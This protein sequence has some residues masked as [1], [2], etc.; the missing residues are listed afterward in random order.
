MKPRQ[1]SEGK[2]IALR[3]VV[4]ENRDIVDEIKSAYQ[5]IS[6]LQIANILEKVQGGTSQNIFDFM[7][8]L[9]REIST[10]ITLNEYD[11]ENRQTFLTPVDPFEIIDSLYNNPEHIKILK[12]YKIYSQDEKKYLP[13]YVKNLI[14]N[15]DFYYEDD[16]DKRRKLKKFPDGGYNYIPITCNNVENCKDEN[17]PYS[18]NDNEMFYHPL[19]YKTKYNKENKK[20]DPLNENACNL[21]EDYRIIYNYKNQNIINL[22]NLIDKKKKGIHEYKKDLNDKI[23]SFSLNTFKI[24]PC[25]SLKSTLSCKKDIHLCF[26]YHSISERRRPPMLFRY[27]NEMCKEQKFDKKGKE[28]VKCRNGDFCNK[29]HT[30]YELYYHQLYFRKTI[31]CLRR[32]K[33]GQCEFLETCYGYHDPNNKQTR[34]E[35]LEEKRDEVLEKYNEEVKI[36]G[37]QINKFRCQYCGKIPIK[38]DFYVILECG[39][40]ICKKCFEKKERIKCPISGCKIKF[41]SKNQEQ[42]KLICIKESA[43]DIDK[44]IKEKYNNKKKEKE[45]KSENE[46]KENS[47]DEVNENEAK[48]VQEE[49]KEE[50]NEEKS[51][52]KKDAINNEKQENDENME[53][54]KE[55]IDEKEEKKDMKKEEKVNDNSMGNE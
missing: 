48:K 8:A 29:C 50:K 51:E 38:L 21:E 27:I 13:F 15:D 25:K 6:E 46:K 32:K 44:F 7:N 4:Y 36:L 3:K 41:D 11:K 34:E 1:F 31:Y 35:K 28:I 2:E 47:S 22:M 49:E 24:F 52:G 18:H 10:Q 5:Y 20:N 17:C 53:E 40:I 16:S 55:K 14:K 26:Y 43:K 23:T 45:N 39:H 19:Y 33:N 12:Y 9:H 42:C 54:K 37:E 30:N